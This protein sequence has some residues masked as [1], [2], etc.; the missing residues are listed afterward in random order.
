MNYRTYLCGQ[1]GAVSAVP[2]RKLL[3]KE[4][5][6]KSDTGTQKHMVEYVPVTCTQRYYIESETVIVDQTRIL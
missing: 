6:S 5:R 4:G 3:K 1:V 2:Y